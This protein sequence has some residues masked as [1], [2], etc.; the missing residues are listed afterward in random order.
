MSFEPLPG[1]KRATEQ[2]ERFRAVA[3]KIRTRTDATAKGL[4]AVGTAAVTAIGYTKL[5]DV[6]PYG[7]PCWAVVILPLGVIAMVAAV[8]YLVLAFEGVSKT[9]ATNSDKQGTRD[10][11]SLDAEDQK[12]IAKAY[13]QTARLNDVPSLRAY[14][15]K[16][17][18]FERI[19][20]TLNPASAAVR[21][22]DLRAHA[23][24]IRA[25]VLATQDRAA[26]FI[27]RRRAKSALFG[28]P[29]VFWLVIFVIGWYGTALAAD[30]MEGERSGEIGVVKSCA[31][32]REANPE[33]KLP[34]I[35]GDAPAEEET[36]AADD[37]EAAV[38]TLGVALV[39]C[40]TKARKAGE[41]LATCSSL[42]RALDAAR[43]EE[44]P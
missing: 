5:A 17:H 24:Q 29:T 11:N 30:A 22:N 33:A 41:D 39:E 42:R 25:E 12:E 9:I 20:D 16:A 14:E 31:E 34:G 3:D 8:V 7:G 13:D 27:L 1:A 43:A 37:A 44:S 18:R 6:F 4:A 10:L 40:R 15:A 35:C 21:I 2:T 23:D 26:V 38:G 19:A 36:S 32:A 28:G